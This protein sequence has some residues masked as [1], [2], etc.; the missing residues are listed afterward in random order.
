MRVG[1]AIGLF[2]PG[3]TVIRHY[4][5]LE[6]LFLQFSSLL[7]VRPSELDAVIWHEMAYSPQTARYLARNLETRRRYGDPARAYLGHR[8][9]GIDLNA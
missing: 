2:P 5:K 1:Q 7:D 4:K 6:Q 3:L 9:R 8:P